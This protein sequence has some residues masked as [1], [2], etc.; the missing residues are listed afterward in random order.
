MEQAA[1]TTVTDRTTVDAQVDLDASRENV[2]LRDEAQGFELGVLDGME[3]GRL[4]RRLPAL[5]AHGAKAS[6]RI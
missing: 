3:P 4:Q 2:L 1:T 5:E 6:E